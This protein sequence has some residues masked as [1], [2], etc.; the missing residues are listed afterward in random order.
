MH[1]LVDWEGYGPEERSWVPASRI[2][3]RSLLTDFHRDHPDQ[4]SLRRGRPRG[5]PR[6]GRAPRLPVPVPPAGVA[7]VVRD[8]DAQLSDRSEEF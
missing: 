8:D 2:L 6:P 3:D 1:Y 5:R 4:P 7:G